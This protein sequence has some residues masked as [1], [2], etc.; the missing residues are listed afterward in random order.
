MTQSVVLRPY[1]DRT[2][3]ALG[4]R[5]L[6]VVALIF[7]A[8]FYG[9]AS[10]V[11]PMSMMFMVAAP[12]FFVAALC[13]WLLPDIGGYHSATYE[14]LL[15]WFIA[16]HIFWPGYV[17]LTLPGFPWI[18]PL[19]VVT[20]TLV[21]VFLLNFATSAELRRTARESAM[22]EPLVGRL[23][24]T[25]WALTTVTVLLSKYPAASFT[26]YI[27]NQI[28]WTLMFVLGAML[29]RR[30]GFASKALTW[31]FVAVLPTAIMGILE[32]RFQ[33]VLWLEYLPTWLW[34]DVELVSEL[35]SSS[36]RAGTEQYRVRGTTL[37]AL[38]YAEY[39]AMIFPVGLFLLW[40][41]KGI[42]K[43]LLVMAAL[44]LMAVVMFLTGS[45]TAMAGILVAIVAFIFFAAWLL[46]A[47]NQSSLGATATLV[48][49]PAMVAVV[50]V[51]LLTWNRMRVMILGG[52]QHQSSDFARDVQWA[53]G[54]D[55][56][57]RNP[58]GHGTMQSA[59]VLGYTNPSGEV[60]ID[61]YFL[62][63]MLDYGVIAL[64]IFVAMFSIPVWL[65][66]TVSRKKWQDEEIEWMIPI[67]I[68]L[69]NFV[70]I[71][72]VLSSESNMP[73]AF[74]LLGFAVA[75]AGRMRAEQAGNAPL[76]ANRSLVG[77]AGMAQ[78]AE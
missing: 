77:P 25:F 59:E 72:S 66:W 62:S 5:I 42:F 30:P 16:L 24:W 12:I 8:T 46:R 11:I 70:I 17:A 60:T 68:S 26:K 43:K 34:G 22:G 28:F 58:L 19:R 54:F 37:V 56:L 33:K 63:V 13:L 2:P 35:L 31:A 44:M 51:L 3:L 52:G 53:N 23:F 74:V 1:G 10:A 47:K 55:I 64:P 48:A 49:Y 73:V 61:T 75:L 4:W 71:K 67:G 7:V 57:L 21:V 65:A 27:N 45:R 38:Y 69:L 36:A 14:K 78:P 6:L 32:Y 41:A 20:A 18:G 29:A 9:M 40:K 76:P 15:T 39:L 50:G